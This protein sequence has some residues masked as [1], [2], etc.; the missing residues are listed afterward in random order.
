MNL[1]SITSLWLVLSPLIAGLFTGT[2]GLFMPKRVGH[3][4]TIGAMASAF[5][6]S[7]L[8][9]KGILIDHQA[10]VN[11]NFYT[12]AIS[13]NFN[14]QIGF[15]IDPLS[16][17]M[18]VVVC[19]I[20]LLVHIYS[21]G[22]MADDT[23][24]P[25]F[26]C[27]M[28]LFTFAMLSL[29]MANNF[30]L[31][32]FGWEGVG[33]VSYLLIGFWFK[34]PSANS[35]SLKAFI[36]NRIADCAFFLGIATIYATFHS[37]DYAEVFAH[38]NAAVNLR[39]SLWPDTPWPVISVICILLFI[40]AMGKSAQVPLH[41]WLPESMEGP[42]PISA[43]IHAATMVTAGIY[44]LARLSPL[45]EQSTAALSFVL[46]IGATQ[47]LFMG[48][49]GIVQTDIKRV[50][51]YS[52]LS[53]LGY[54]VAG[55]GSSAFDASMFHLFTHACF[56]ALLFLAA[57]AVIIA[58]HHEQDIRKMGGLARS[59][60]ITYVCFFIGAL[61]LAAIPPSAGFYSK[62]SILAAV[63]QTTIFGG[64]YA[65]FC[66]LAGVFVTAFYIFRAFFSVFHGTK[67]TTAVHEATPV[68]W[69]PL[70]VLSLAALCIGA[71][72]IY[73]LLISP[74]NWFGHSIT[75]LPQYNSLGTFIANYHSAAAMALDALS[76]SAF[77]LGIAGIAAA[78]LC[79]VAYPT[80]PARLAQRFSWCYAVLTHEYGFNAFNQ[81]VFVAG[82]L[83]I[84]DVF[85][86]RIDEQLIDEQCVNG[87]GRILHVLSHLARLLQS[88][89]LYRYALVMVTGLLALVVWQ[90]WGTPT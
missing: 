4:I 68:M 52:T 55:L 81:K 19:F 82:S 62:D 28:S 83:R 36:V 8:L 13:H 59:M 48:L 15:L 9:S 80:L 37:V 33:L 17:M 63:E 38:I 1:L 47:A 21:I 78:W 46:I 85:A 90:M 10:A 50:I 3:I 65:Y 34:R 43:L 30:L 35:A 72:C 7:L 75:V 79:Y 58:M 84:A 66:L 41:V 40:G 87:S 69:W 11:I 73:P 70:V 44:L 45:Y 16:V 71:L 24:N 61:A 56:K 88:G 32:F 23:S 31:L 74:N 76:H 49:V 18:S 39:M 2:A 20:S 6:A 77:W 26:F 42:T 64:S 53:Q 57:G 25:R 12:W 60:P 54:M 5:C 22:Y 29:V 51:A 67:T 14:V 86:H 27:Y 89:Y